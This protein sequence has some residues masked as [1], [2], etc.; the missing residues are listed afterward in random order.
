MYG[1]H[2]L[3]ILRNRAIP[4]THASFAYNFP[5][6]FGLAKYSWNF[7]KEIQFNEDSTQ[8][9]LLRSIRSPEVNVVID[10]LYE[11]K[12]INHKAVTIN[13]ALEASFGFSVGIWF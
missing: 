7:W 10:A 11:Q 2:L 13:F 8:V 3:K 12:S 4:Y 5:V 1:L 6:E 9:A